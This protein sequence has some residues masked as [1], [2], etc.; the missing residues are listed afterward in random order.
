LL[1][2]WVTVAVFV[3]I[4]ALMPKRLTWI[5]MYAT[6]W[7]AISLAYT[8]DVYLDLRFHLYGYF[9]KGRPDF[10]TLIILFGLYPTF[11]AIYLNFF[12]VGKLLKQIWYIIGNV[13]FLVGYEWLTLKIGVLYYS[14]W[15]LGYSALC[16]PLILLILYW[17][18][19][20][21]KYLLAKV[22]R[23]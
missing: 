9:T 15:K 23:R 18:L 13:A 6:A 14:G 20:I 3:A 17:N 2:L 1:L 10:E 5:E 12:P 11:N 8:A 16:Y 19:R 21:T 4:I 7:F 22:S